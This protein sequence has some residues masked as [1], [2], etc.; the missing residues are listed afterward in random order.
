MFTERQIFM[1]EGV[2]SR[3]LQMQMQMSASMRRDKADD[4]GWRIRDE[5][6]WWG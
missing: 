6:K 2:E 1:E 3:M 4:W 5:K